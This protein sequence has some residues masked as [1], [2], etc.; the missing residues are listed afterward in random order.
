MVTNVTVAVETL[1]DTSMLAPN[2]TDEI[3]DAVATTNFSEAL[4]LAATNNTNVI[5]ESC[6]RLDRRSNPSPSGDRVHHR[7]DHHQRHYYH[8]Q[9][10]RRDPGTD[11]CR[12]TR[13]GEHCNHVQ[14]K[15][16]ECM[17]A[18]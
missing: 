10:Q 3:V 9:R 5:F 16:S 4:A 1:L 7:L 6:R 8:R 14:F 17:R 15:S 12:R 13:R 2:V 18:T 11:Q